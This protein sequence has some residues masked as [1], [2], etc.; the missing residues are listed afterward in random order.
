MPALILFS[1][2][3][4]TETRYVQLRDE[5]FTEAQRNE[6]LAEFP[7]PLG[8]DLNKLARSLISSTKLLDMSYRW[9][10]Y[11]ENSVNS[12]EW[13]RAGVPFNGIFETFP[14]EWDILTS[15]IFPTFPSN[16]IP[17][18]I[19]LATALLAAKISLKFVTVDNTIESISVE[20]AISISFRPNSE[21]FVSFDM[22]P[23]EV[24]MYARKYAKY[25]LPSSNTPSNT[26]R[27]FRRVT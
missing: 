20:N 15:S 21:N 18:E 13:P 3:Y 17:L 1:N 19:E 12:L 14:P 5:Y 7:D 27:I 22:I 26:V 8:A 2:T 6:S 10:G 11:K 25:R 24:D 9:L 16:S 4:V 23:A